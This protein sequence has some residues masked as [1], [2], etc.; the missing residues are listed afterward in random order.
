MAGPPLQNTNIKNRFK[1]LPQGPTGMYKT[2]NDFGVMMNPVIAELTSSK[3]TSS[4]APIGTPNTYKISSVHERRCKVE[5]SDELMMQS[6]EGGKRAA[7]GSR[8]SKAS[9]IRSRISG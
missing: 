6:R 9:E 1:N 2:Q 5:D 4:R 7:V 8:D 3:D